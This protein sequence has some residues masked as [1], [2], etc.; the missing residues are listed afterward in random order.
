M[1][2]YLYINVVYIELALHIYINKVLQYLEWKF[3]DF[4][5]SIFVVLG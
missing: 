5:N 2:L 3:C 1:L 4:E